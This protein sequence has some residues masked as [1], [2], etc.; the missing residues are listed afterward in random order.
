MMA[1]VLAHQIF[2][3]DELW[4]KCGSLLIETLCWDTPSK[5][6]LK[7]PPEFNTIFYMSHLLPLFDHC[8][9]QMTVLHICKAIETASTVGHICDITQLI[10]GETTKC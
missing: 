9:N 8:D 3:K 10:T 5:Y 6:V 1:K 4:I 7:H 2:L